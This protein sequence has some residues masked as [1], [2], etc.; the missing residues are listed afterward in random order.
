VF[1]RKVLQVVLAERTR[2]IQDELAH[3]VDGL[4]EPA[5]RDR[6]AFAVA[7]GRRFRPLM[8]LLAC[9]GVGG[10]WKDAVSLACSLE[11]LHK[12]SLLHDDLVDG[13]RRRRGKATF[14][15]RYGAHDAT[16][17]GDLLVALAFG[18]ARNGTLAFTDG[19][20][21][22][23]PDVLQATLRDLAIGE[24]QDLVFE[25]EPD[26]SA[27]DIERM[28]LLKSG[29][30]VAASLQIGALAGG[31]D[32]EL[33][34]RLTRLG[35]ELGVVFQMINDINNLNEVD[36]QSKGD[37]GGDLQRG[38]KTLATLC[39]REAGLAAEDLA[40]LEPGE[41]EALLT[42]ARDAL[43]KANGRARET[44]AALPAGQMRMLFE[45]LLDHAEDRW[46]WVDRDG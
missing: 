17:T 36:Q 10:R 24:M 1:L 38:K 18:A 13:D 12:A 23:A 6:V 31:A 22:R 34:Q 44:C 5:I 16:I 9:E 28:L 27:A 14:W 30:L 41:L 25:S 29:T 4:A 20:A 26:V 40:A 11:L 19:R 8:A 42:P 35:G 7:T 2:A 46:F 45:Q 43:S 15:S 33:E 37:A 21:Q 3:V 32:E 39:L